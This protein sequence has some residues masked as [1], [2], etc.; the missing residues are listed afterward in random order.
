MG[1]MYYECSVENNTHKQRFK[2]NNI[3]TM[4]DQNQ[5]KQ[6]IKM[7]NEGQNGK[8]IYKPKTKG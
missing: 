5:I 6:N 7:W 1:Q 4:V 2:S 8:V 3:K